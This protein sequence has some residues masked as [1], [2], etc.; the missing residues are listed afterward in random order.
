[1]TGGAPVEPQ[2]L[3]ADAEA[4][5]MAKAEARVVHDHADVGD[6]VVEPLQLE[7]DGAPPAPGSRPVR[8]PRWCRRTR[9]RPARASVRTAA[10]R[11]ASP[12]PCGRSPGASRG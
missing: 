2:Q 10:S 6:V 12:C 8:G 1:M 3:L 11:R 7:Q 9:A 5:R 4:V